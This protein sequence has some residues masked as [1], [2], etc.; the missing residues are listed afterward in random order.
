MNMR[1][2]ISTN[3]PTRQQYDTTIV[4]SV[5]LSPSPSECI[6]A[7]KSV[8]GMNRRYNVKVEPTK[9]YQRERGTHVE[10]HGDGTYTITLTPQTAGPHQLLITGSTALYD[11]HQVIHVKYPLCVAIHENGDIYLGSGDDHL[12]I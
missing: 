4:L 11:V 6:F 10:D 5:D 7:S 2:R 8:P 1:Y 12:C 3:G 9:T